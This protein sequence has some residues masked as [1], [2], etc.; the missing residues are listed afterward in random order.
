MADVRSGVPAVCTYINGYSIQR[1]ARILH[2]I[3][4]KNY[5]P[6]FA[7]VSVVFPVTRPVTQT[8]CANNDDISPLPGGVFLG[9]SARGAEMANF[10]IGRSHLHT[11]IRGGAGNES[12]SDIFHS[13]NS[14]VKR[15]AF[16]ICA[17]NSAATIILPCTMLPSHG[18]GYSIFLPR[19]V[20]TAT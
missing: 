19:G 20:Y 5:P 12:T 6:R 9:A 16:Q 11:L 1:C 15:S 18:Q 10:G 7:E 3:W 8:P 2:G 17:V 4:K 14:C 13:L